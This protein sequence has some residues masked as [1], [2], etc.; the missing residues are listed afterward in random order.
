VGAGGAE[1]ELNDEGDP[2]TSRDSE[3]TDVRQ[4]GRSLYQFPVNFIETY[5]PTRL[6]TDFAAM[7]GGD[8]SGD[9]EN[10]RHDGP[11]MKPILLVQAGDSD[12]NDA[13]ADEGPTQTG[14]KPNDKELSRE[15]ILP[16]YNH[17]D[18]A[19]AAWRQNDGRPEGSSRELARFLLKVIRRR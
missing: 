6:V 13:A 2:Y 8:R 14:E 1:L 12:S 3:V 4:L 18:V 19:T 16:G 17:L 9:L 11:S 15:A 5:F 10:L 7:E